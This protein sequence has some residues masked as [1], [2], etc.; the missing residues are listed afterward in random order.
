M[1]WLNKGLRGRCITRDLKWGTPVPHEKFADKVFYVWFD[2]P[3]GYVS[4]TANLTDEWRRWWQND[5]Q[6][7]LYQF[8]GKDNIP[9]HT[10]IFPASLL[11]TREPWTMLHH[12]STTEYLNYEDGKFSKTNKTGVFGLDAKESGIPSEVWRYYLLANRPEQADTLFQWSDFQAKV[13]DE[14]LACLGNFSYRSL[15]FAK[16]HTEGRVPEYAGERHEND[17]E[18]S[19]DLLSLTVKYVK[20]LEG[21][22]LKEGLK[23]AM[24]VAHT[25]NEYFQGNKPWE[26]RK[27]DL[28]RCKQI[29][30]ASLCGLRLLA[31][32]LEPFMPGYSAKVYEQ[33]GIVRN[34]KEEIFL[35]GIEDANEE[36]FFGF[37]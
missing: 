31:A 4:I 15:S 28:P 3:I 6:V 29:V 18:F 9:F 8:M 36:S 30:A 34:A 25:C 26:Q 5:A 2:A 10:V 1:S 32:L 12:I 17:R 37:V 7:Q 16:N 21:A 20:A 33:L 27:K 14:L 11:A 24:A 35:Q 23:Q 13:N 19:K 22:H